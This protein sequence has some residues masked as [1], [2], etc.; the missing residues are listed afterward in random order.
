[1]YKLRKY[2]SAL[3]YLQKQNVFRGSCQFPHTG[4]NVQGVRKGAG[5][6]SDAGSGCS[7]GERGANLSVLIINTGFFSCMVNGSS[8]SVLRLL[9]NPQLMKQEW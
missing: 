7:L 3:W 5:D 9:K 4:Q 6:V 8:S 2:L 1:M